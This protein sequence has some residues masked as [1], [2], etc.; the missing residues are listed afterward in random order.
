M[1]ARRVDLMVHPRARRPGLVGLA[2]A[3]VGFTLLAAGCSSTP[4]GGPTAESAPASTATP[5]GPS[6]PVSTASGSAPS[7]PTA[8]SSAS[9]DPSAGPSSPAS[10]SPACGTLSLAQ[11]VGQLFVMGVAATGPTAGQLAELGDLQVGGV[12]MMGNT[13]ASATSVRQLTDRV[14]AAGRQPDGVTVMVTVDQEG[15][16]VRRLRGSGFS[17][18]PSAATQATWSSAELTRQASTWGSELRKAGV[19]LDFAPVADVVPASAGTKNQPIGALGRGYGS[20][21]KT[22]GAKVS[23]FIKGMH[24]GREATATKHFPGL[25]RVIGNTDFASKVIDSTTTRDDPLLGGFDAGQAAGAD[26]IMVS[27]AYYT[28]IDADHPAAF[29][30]TVVNGMLRSDR[31][32]RGVVVSDDLGVAKAVTGF[33][34][35]DRAITFLTAGG[36]LVVNVDPATTDDM[37]AAVVAKAEVDPAFARRVAQSADRVLQLKS[38]YGL[39]RCG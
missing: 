2:A 10:S 12:I 36:D 9:K 11:Q 1:V 25:G 14:R 19:D 22:V 18:M 4:A 3:L 26:M 8:S 31:D 16:Q 37:V 6:S 28:K 17:A 30:S 13:S 38:R 27:T 21:P 39:A 24:A 23:A 20:D 34:P 33:S 15:G 35:G 32:Y 29:S 7:S 5:T